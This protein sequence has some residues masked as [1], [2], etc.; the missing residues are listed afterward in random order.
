MN[1]APHP[2]RILIVED[3]PD[4]ARV[5]QFNL[6]RQGHEVEHAATLAAAAERLAGPPFR[7]VLLDLR[8][9]DGSGLDFLAGRR[10]DLPP[11]IVVSALGDETTV[12]EALNRGAEDFVVKPFRIRELLARVSGTLRRH[13]APPAPRTPDETVEDGGLRLDLATHEAN[14]DGEPVTLTRS[15]FRLVL[16]FL[17]HPGRVLT[18]KQLCDEALEAGGSVQERTIDAHIRTI[19][20]KLGNQGQRIATVWGVGYRLVEPGEEE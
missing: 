12:V 6:S 17:R 8:L 5:L 11:V 9:P 20:R 15:E 3:E 13:D 4:M 2:H 10:Q 14:A 18:R 19:R 7:L 1:P 16:H